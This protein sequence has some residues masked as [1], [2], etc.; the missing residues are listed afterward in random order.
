M[1]LWELI[2]DGNIDNIYDFFKINP[3]YLLTS[4]GGELCNYLSPTD[5]ILGCDEILSF[6]A[7]N[8]S[9]DSVSEIISILL[10]FGANPNPTSTEQPLFTV[11]LRTQS[12]QKPMQLLLSA[13]ANIHFTDDNVSIYQRQSR[14]K[15]YRL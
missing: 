5:M 10:R 13:G 3:N 9:D 15:I 14:S 11:A 6:A 4:T 7:R 12:P 1:D 8:A 2:S